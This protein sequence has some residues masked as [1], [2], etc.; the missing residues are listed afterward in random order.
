MQLLIVVM[1]KCIHYWISW[2]IN[3]LH[4]MHHPIVDFKSERI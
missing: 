1:S 3:V 4:W 2:H